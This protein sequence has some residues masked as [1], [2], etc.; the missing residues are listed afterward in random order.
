MM[1]LSVKTAGAPPATVEL[2]V[3]QLE[4]LVTITGAGS[5][6]GETGKVNP[7]LLL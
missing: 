5:A 7:P 6:R 4:Q 3:T 2:A 1:I